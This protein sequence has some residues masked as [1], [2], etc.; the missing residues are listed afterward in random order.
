MYATTL[1]SLL[2]FV[3]T[4]KDEC[5]FKIPLNKLKVAT[6]LCKENV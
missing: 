4:V 6:Q 1:P 2:C 3:V 5:I